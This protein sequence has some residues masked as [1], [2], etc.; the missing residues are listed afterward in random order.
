MPGVLDI[1]LNGFV[2]C[3]SMLLS[4]IT[5]VWF[6]LFPALRV[7][8]PDLASLLR[9]NGAAA[10]HTSRRRFF[11]ISTRGF[12]VVCQ[13]ALSIVLLI[14]ASLL[15]R[16][17]ARLRGVDPGFQPEHV[18]TAEVPLPPAHYDTFLKKGVFFRDLLP[19]LEY[20]PGVVGAAAA[21]SVPTTRSIGTSIFDVEG[22]P[23]PD[24]KDPAYQAIWQSISPAYFRTLEIPLK[25]GRVF[26]EHDNTPGAPPVV[27]VNEH[28][29]RRLWPNANPI[30]RHIKEASDKGAGWMEVVGVAADIHESGLAADAQS[31]IYV[32]CALHPP[33]T[34]YLILRTKGDPLRFANILRAQVLAID[35]NQGVS[36][37]QTLES[38]LDATLGQRR[39]TMLLLG[40]FAGVALLLALIGIYGVV[41]YS[42]AQRT[43]EVGIRRALGAQ[44][45][46]I[47]SLVVQQGLTLTL[48]GGAFGIGGSLALTRIMKGLLFDVSAT[49][50]AT[51]LGTALLF[52][53]VASIASYIPARRAARIDPMEALRN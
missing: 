13:I 46:D 20:L 8:R 42:V 24:P 15:M 16:S 52:V 50:P 18:L 19:R 39:L 5:G 6:G 21:Q 11:R 27:I 26:T 10:G 3:F 1:Q 28:L 14:G 4:V 47:L 2:L 25:Q 12:L 43:Q 49:D 38:M 34:A 17:F 33:Q 35:P 41:A 36:D 45:F 9:E 30:G 51:F 23:A 31:E 40:S 32:P 48:I 53:A 44:Q 29:A 7:S 22:G 37:V